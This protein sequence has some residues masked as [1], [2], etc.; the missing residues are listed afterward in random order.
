VDPSVIEVARGMGMTRRQ[1]LFRVELPMSLPVIMAGI[2]IAT[3]WTIGIATLVCLVGAGGL[4]D[5]IMQGLRSFKLDYLAAG[6]LPAAALAL[7]ADTVL[8]M[9]E[10]LLTPKGMRSKSQTA[11]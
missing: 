7:V 8:S 5:L 10:T 3:V 1:I 4:G 2:R 6:T 9:L 11:V